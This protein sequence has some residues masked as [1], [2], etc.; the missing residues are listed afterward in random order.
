[1]TRI[2]GITL[3]PHLNDRPGDYPTC[4]GFA[5]VIFSRT[6]DVNFL[7][8]A[9]PW[10]NSGKSHFDVLNT[11]ECKE[12]V[13]FGLRALEKSAW[14]KLKEEYLAYHQRLVDEINSVQDIDSSKDIVQV[15]PTVLSKRN[16]EQ[17]EGVPQN[18]VKEAASTGPLAVIDLTSPYPFN[19]LVFVKHIHPETNK[20]TLRSFFIAP[21]K[22]LL[23]KGE[24]VTDGVDYVDFGKGMDSVGSAIVSR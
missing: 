8:N 3:P 19:C 21:F 23:S 13:K 1:M 2:Q 16:H 6:D 20:T 18:L 22:N 12:A 17:I 5:L 10:R 15:H 4:K 11:V 9:W 14:E 7:L 24:L